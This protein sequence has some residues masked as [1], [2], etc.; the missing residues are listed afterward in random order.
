MTTVTIARCAVLCF[1][2]S[3]AVTL[4]DTG[5]AQ[6]PGDPPPAPVPTGIFT[7]RRVFISNA[8]GGIALAPGDPDLTYNESYAETLM[9][10]WGRYELA[11]SPAEA[12]LV[13]EIRFTFVVGPTGVSQ[14]SGCSTQD[15]PFRLI[16]F[17]PK[18]RTVFW[19]FSEPIPHSGHQAKSRQFF[20]QTMGVIV[21]DLKKLS[22]RGGTRG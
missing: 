3:L 5:A 13:L 1:V 10:G 14:G 15:Y 2:F 11:G 16:A 4:A 7:A 18:S 20:D 19:A 8:T 22:S 9:K 17:G 12:G 6:K 21:D